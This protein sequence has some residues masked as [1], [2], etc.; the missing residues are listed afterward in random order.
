MKLM[1]SMHH[2]PTVNR[3]SMSVRHE[4][5]VHKEKF[6]SEMREDPNYSSVVSNTSV[7]THDTDVDMG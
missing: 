3:I 7:N 5:Q 6:Q 1:L 2:R 4:I